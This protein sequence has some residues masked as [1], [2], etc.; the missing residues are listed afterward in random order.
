MCRV[1]EIL[2]SINNFSKYI[3]FKINQINSFTEIFC[4]RKF[5]TG[6]APGCLLREG[7]TA[8]LLP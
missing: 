6:A 7:K 3:K 5:Q 1:Q 4:L 2:S 8:S